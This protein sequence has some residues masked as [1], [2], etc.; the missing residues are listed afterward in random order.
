MWNNNFDGTVVVDIPDVVKN[1]IIQHSGDKLI[2]AYQNKEGSFVFD[3][4]NNNLVGFNNI[5]YPTNLYLSSELTFYKTFLGQYIDNIENTKYNFKKDLS[6]VVMKEV[7]ARTE[8]LGEKKGFS[9]YVSP[10]L[11]SFLLNSDIQINKRRSLG[12]A[13]KTRSPL[14]LSSFN[15][16][17]QKVD[18]LLARELREPQMWDAYHIVE[19]M[20]SANFSVPGAGKTSIVYGAFAYLFDKKEV[21][22][23]VMIGPINSFMAWKKE[24]YANFGNKLE[25]RCYDYQLENASNAADRYDHIVYRTKDT[26]L[27]LINYDALMNNEDALKEIIN[28]KTLLVFDEVHRIKS[29]TGKRALSALSLCKRARYRVVLTGT[30]IPNGYI[31]IFNF[32]HILFEDEYDTFFNF[33]EQYLKEAKS[34]E[35]NQQQINDKL[36]PFF[37]RTTKKD[38]NVPPPNDDDVTSGYCQFDSFDEELFGIIYRRFRYNTLLLYVR[39]MQASSNPSLLL[40][41]ISDEDLHSFDTDEEDNDFSALLNQSNKKVFEPDEEEFIKNFGMTKKFWK[42]LDLI[43][44]IVNQNKPVVVWGIFVDTLNKLFEECKNRNISTR[45]ITGSVPPKQREQIIKDF[46]DGKFSVLITNPHTLAE[47]VSLH[48]ICHDAIYLEYSFNLVHMLQ[49]RDRIHRLGLVDG[50]ETN[51]YYMMLDNGGDLYNSIDRKIYDRLKYKEELQN[52]AIEGHNLVYYEED[53]QDD[54]DS[55]DLI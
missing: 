27:F 21:D 36:Y 16:F 10:S 30:P 47:S 8:E 38:L 40:N 7:I 4:E 50:Q 19:M 6:Y 42:T 48:T 41:A 14:L 46:L 25:M 35:E 15:A 55:L 24:F 28:S 45:I 43:E 17:K 23:I 12:Q 26:N 1:Q 49:S 44:N 9:I 22:K 53:I 52:N 54:I 31:D 51:Y 18:S 5:E 29:T 39:L 33:S 11:R 37:C 20:R 32:L 2:L 13:I 3:L 34:N